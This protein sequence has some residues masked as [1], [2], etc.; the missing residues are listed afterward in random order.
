MSITDLTQ[1][2]CFIHLVHCDTLLWFAYT[3]WCDI[4]QLRKVYS[5]VKSAE[6]QTSFGRK[7]HQGEVEYLVASFNM[8]NVTEGVKS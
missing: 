7:R 3:Y 6:L 4:V 5:V 1:S 2:F 8:L